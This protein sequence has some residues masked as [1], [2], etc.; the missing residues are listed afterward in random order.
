MSYFKL[1]HRAIGKQKSGHVNQCDSTE[2]LSNRCVE[3]QPVAVLTNVP[4]TDDKMAA[5]SAE[6]ARR[7]KCMDN[8]EMRYLYLT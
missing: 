6:D 8:N 7:D 3:L 5:S 1:S 4:E 2:R